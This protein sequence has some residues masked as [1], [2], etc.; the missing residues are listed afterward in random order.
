MKD[1]MD[2]YDGYIHVWRKREG[3]SG[4]AKTF[5]PCERNIVRKKKSYL[6]SL[7][8]FNFFLGLIRDRERR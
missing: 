2:D 7:F 3:E 5:V 8:D 6:S 1:S 4:Y